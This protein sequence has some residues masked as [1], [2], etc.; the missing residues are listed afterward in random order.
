MKLYSLKYYFS[1]IALL[2]SLVCFSQSENKELLLNQNAKELMYSNP[3][4]A[5]N[6]T[7]LMLSKPSITPS[8]EAK[9]NF[10]TAKIYKAKGDYSNSLHF[11]FEEKKF[12]EYLSDTEKLTIELEK[13]AVLRE[14]SLDKEAKDILSLVENNTDSKGNAEFKTFKEASV[15]LEKS[16]FLNKEQ[17]YAEAIEMLVNERR[18]SN[19][20]DAFPELKLSYA[21]ALGQL[22]IENR[23]IELAK[24]HFDEALLLL[25]ENKGTNNYQKIFVLSGLA[26]VYFQEK[27][28]EKA[29]DALTE[30]YDY[31]IGLQNTYLQESIINKLLI[32]YLAIG[33]TLHYKLNNVKLIQKYAEIEALD[34]A[35][36]NTAYNL[37]SEDQSEKYVQQESFYTKTIIAFIVLGCLVVCGLL[38]FWWGLYQKKKRLKEI[39]Y[40]LNIS[41]NN[42]I[43]KLSV[44]VEESKK[45]NIPKETEQLLLKKLERFENSTRFTNKDFSLAV[46]A[47]QFDTNTKYLS[48][49]INSN[50]NMNFNTYINNLRIKYIVD[51]LKNE[52]NFIS[53]KIS[54]LA[55][56]CGFSSHSSFTTVFKSLTGI[57]PVTYIELLRK[58]KEDEKM[59]VEAVLEYE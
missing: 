33:D 44:K 31:A 16:A 59:A 50:F 20:L 29:I 55:E 22:Y 39:I 24:K 23:N 45:V 53:Y 18:K 26:S 2:F 5:I 8:E 27:K 41:R 11:L 25:N 19:N 51:K 15:V 46:L 48:E 52:P 32:N 30:A 43:N 38:F 9:I 34:Q 42:F 47:S 14:L 1:L 58:E 21:I 13:A 4:Q 6:I 37:I 28:H 56:N 12:A 17:K 40:Y 54:Y 35:A 10:L 3:E 7:K 57:S 36:V 49:V